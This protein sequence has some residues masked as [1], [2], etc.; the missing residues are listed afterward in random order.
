M[1]GVMAQ[2]VCPVWIG[3]LLASPIRK[4]MHNPDAI[5]A[6]YVREGMTVLDFGCAMGFFSIPLARMVG[7]NGKVICVDMQEKMLKR[8]EKRA[9]KAGASNRMEIRLCDQHSLGLQEFAGRID[10]ALAF[11]VVHE[12]PDPPRL[13]GELAGVLKP[14]GRLFMAEPKGH[15]R[16][17]DFAHTVTVAEEQAFTVVERPKIRRSWAVMLTKTR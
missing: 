14:G 13:F 6:P 12:V 15:V 1:E 16:E 8:L 7:A 10:F 4:M 11:A 5:L 9:R 17:D 2:R 3:Y